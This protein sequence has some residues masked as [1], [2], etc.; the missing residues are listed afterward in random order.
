MGES[1]PGFMQ[2]TVDTITG[3][4]KGEVFSG[5]R[6]ECLEDAL[7]KVGERNE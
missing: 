2:A 6:G 5:A 3:M 4:R 1:Q 7:Y